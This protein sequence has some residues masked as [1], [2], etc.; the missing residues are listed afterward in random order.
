MKAYIEALVDDG[1]PI[2]R[3]MGKG[4]VVLEVAAR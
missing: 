2:P 1:F 3:E 4:S